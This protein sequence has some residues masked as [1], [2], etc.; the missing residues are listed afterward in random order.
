[1]DRGVG[2]LLLLGAAHSLNHSLFLVLPPLL[3]IVSSDLGASYQTLGLIV[4]VS[5]LIYGL[6]SLVGGPLADR[7]GEV[8][9]AQISIALAGVSTA[10]FLLPKS[11]YTL[12]AGLW[13]VAVWASFYHPTSNTLISR[14]FEENTGGAMGVHGAAASLGQMFTPTAAF[15]LG[16]WMDWRFP[17]VFFGLLSVAT[18]LAMSRIPSPA[19]SGEKSA[20]VLEIL[21]VPNIWILMLFN[22]FV[23]LFFRGVEL[24]LP[25]FLSSNRGFSGQEAAVA[26]S[27]VLL[28]GVF[29][30]LVGGR[31]SDRY[32]PSRV[33]IVASV[34]ILASMLFLLMPLGFLGVAAF[35]LVYGVAL[36]GHQPAMTAL[37]GR[38]APRSLMGTAY[39]VMFFFAF[40]LGSVSTSIAGYLADTFSLEVAFWI[41]ALFAGGILL[42]AL[43]IPRYVRDRVET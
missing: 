19:R 28:V 3:E 43:L 5:Y 42:I 36:F 32:G 34:G 16:V 30:Q 15:L 20:P 10:V 4:T 27:I 9:I 11:V 26:N 1:M 31:A 24:F 37:L 21:R 6:G 14:L 38:V 41:L 12:G 40:G 39:G 29:G 7:V 23:G 33:V 17:F 2:V 22:V 13:L 25:A 18:G 8:R 35:I